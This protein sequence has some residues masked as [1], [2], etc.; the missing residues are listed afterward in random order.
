M[1]TA[2]VIVGTQRTGTT[3][4]RTSLDSHPEVACSGEVFKT[5]RRPY[6]EPDGYWA[7]CREAP[8][9]RLRHYVARRRNCQVF[10]TRLLSRPG[11]RAIGFK[12]MYSHALRYPQVIDYIRRGGLRVIHVT[13]RNY[14]RTLISRDVARLTGVYHRTA[15]SATSSRESITLDPSTLVQRLQNVSREEQ[16]WDELLRG[17]SAVH[18]LSYEDFVESRAAVTQGLLQFLE[19]GYATL[20]S[21]LEKLNPSDLRQLIRNY[22][23]V[24][25][26]LKPTPFHSLLDA[27]GR[28]AAGVIGGDS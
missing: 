1:P 24:E 16:A 11:A 17:H 4:I 2:F 5:G 18:K 26:V 12:M 23:E 22:D 14:L 9:N 27:P 3:L 7:F 13:R 6:K 10:L 8:L 15:G 19:L 20:S 28:D 25:A 21:T